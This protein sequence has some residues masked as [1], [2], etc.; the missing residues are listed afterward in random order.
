MPL[1]KHKEEEIYF[2]LQG[3]EEILISFTETRPIVEGDSVYIPK[4]VPHGVKNTSDTDLM[5]LWVFPAD[6][7]YDVTYNYMGS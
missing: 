6:S 5:F 7:W 4:G 1:H 2:F 3:K